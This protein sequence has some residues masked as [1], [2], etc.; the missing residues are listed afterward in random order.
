MKSPLPC[1]VLAAFI[2]GLSFAFA[3]EKEDEP[4]VKLSKDEQTILDL[5]NAARAKEDLKPLKA[6]QLLMDAAKAH[7]INMGKQK[8]LEHELDGMAPVDR[9]KGTGYKASYAGENIAMT[10]KLSP[11]QAM[12]VWMKS[13]PHKANILNEKFEEFGVAMG[14][15]VDGKYYYTQV[16]GTPVK[17]RK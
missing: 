14:R 13:P 7:T 10:P 5:V 2:C 6:A 1:F 11:T 4:K 15:G 8:K 12:Q 17:G 9:I 3:A 16:F